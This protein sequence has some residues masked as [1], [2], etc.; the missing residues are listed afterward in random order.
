[1]ERDRARVA[2]MH[3]AIDGRELPKPDPDDPKTRIQTAFLTAAFHDPEVARA[4]AEFL[5][6]MALPQEIMA[7]PGMLDKVMSAAEGREPPPMP[8]PR[9]DE[10]LKILASA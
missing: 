7:R 10:L 2:V 8:G 5:S 4:M 1:M 6:V 9:R 3:A